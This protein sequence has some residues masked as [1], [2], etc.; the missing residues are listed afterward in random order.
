MGVGGYFCV[1]AV[2]PVENAGSEL[3]VVLKGDLLGVAP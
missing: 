2:A 1:V 3:K